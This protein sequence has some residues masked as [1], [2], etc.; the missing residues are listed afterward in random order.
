MDSRGFPGRG[1]AGFP[2]ARSQWTRLLLVAV[3]LV[4]LG[5]CGGCRRDDAKKLATKK[6]KEDFELSR[7]ATFP[8]SI[9][10]VES[11]IKPGHWTSASLDAV[12]NNFDF[13][14]EL[15]TDPVDLS[16][17]TYR[18]G[19]ARTVLLPK[20]QRRGVELPFFIPRDSSARTVGVRLS[21]RRGG[22]EVG[23]GVFPFNRLPAHQFYL[24]VLARQ[25]DAYSYLRGLP[26][27][28]PP[29]HDILDASTNAHYRVLTPPIDQA[30]PL[31]SYPLCWTS[32]A[33]L[34]WDD[35]DPTLFSQAQQQALVDWLHWG[36]Q[37]IVSGPATLDLLRGCFLEPW[38]PAESHGSRT[39]S[40]DELQPLD[41]VWSGRE[42]PL[43]PTEPWSGVMLSPRPAARV[44]VGSP[45][46]PLVVEGSV[47]RGR[48]VVSAFH[49]AQRELVAWSGLDGFVHACLLR[50]P[51]RTFFTSDDALVTWRWADEPTALHAHGHPN[52]V[53]RLAY[54]T[55]DENGPDGSPLQQQLDDLNLPPVNADVVDG[56]GV[57]GWTDQGPAANSAR[58]ALREASGISIPDAGFVA[59]TLGWY[60]LCLVPL[61]WALFRLLRRL[62]WAWA[63]VPVLAVVFA[64]LVTRFAQLDMG[65]V[66]AQ[67]EVNVVELQGGYR[68]AHV[69]RYASLYSS[70]TTNYDITFDDA[71]AAVMP[72]SAAGNDFVLR[73]QARWL[74]EYRREER[75][76]LR[77]FTVAS[78]SIGMLHGEHH[79]D[80]GGGL[81]LSGTGDE[82]HNRTEIDLEGLGLAG[83]RGWAW[84]DRMVANSQSRLTWTSWPETSGVPLYQVFAQHWDRSPT[85]RQSVASGEFN[86][87][88][89]VELAHLTRPSQE[90]R[91]VAWSTAPVAGM[92]VA[93]EA[94]QRRQVSVVLAHLD[95][96]PLRLP[97]RDALAEWELTLAKPDRVVEEAKP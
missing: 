42:L 88:R 97:T 18:F 51:P 23:R 83:P 61:N 15:A 92:S 7:L 22:G 58:A 71:G 10:T 21:S 45:E 4:A 47:G 87:R 40:Q 26:S 50:R 72:F 11:A 60:L 82:L 69:T 24:C 75:L 33:C 19:T 91:L 17:S 20:G 38:L 16:R 31:A 65:F 78:N 68:R 57:A 93:P 5:G 37:L 63:M 84:V 13:R 28:T 12:S 6:P 2:V 25:P 43:R 94:S 74:A 76:H 85:T 67:T 95:Q 1:V 32:V 35:L 39:W 70:L 48:I 52:R 36:G 3:G 79:L 66:R 46:A 9:D 41:T 62:E 55:R 90:T 80:L 77:G 89:L 30:V 73:D 49:L 27:I 8:H 54:F 81:E 14:G 53:S 96:P 34:W 29:T 59:R 86:V 56:P 44:I 64:F